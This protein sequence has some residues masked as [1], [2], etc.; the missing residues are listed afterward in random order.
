MEFRE[1]ASACPNTCDDM[2][3]EKKCNKPTESG[4]MCKKGFVL[5]GFD[6]VPEEE[7]GCTFQDRYYKVYLNIVCT[8]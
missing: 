6:C 2:E 7:C 4:C 3:A 8:K 1:E 5:S